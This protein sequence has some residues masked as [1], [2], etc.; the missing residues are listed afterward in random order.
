MSDKTKKP[1]SPT[2]AGGLVRAG[3]DPRMIES[4]P[5]TTRSTQRRQKDVGKRK[6]S[7]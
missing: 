1:T 3:R 7:R 4:L 2:V 5:P 6:N